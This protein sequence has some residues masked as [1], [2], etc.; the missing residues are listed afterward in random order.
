M[1][2]L[3]IHTNISFQSKFCSNSI[4][5]ITSECAKKNKNTNTDL[6][7]IGIKT[8]QTT[9]DSFTKTITETEKTV[10][11]I[12]KNNPKSE[13]ILNIIHASEEECQKA[14]L[15]FLK[16]IKNITLSENE[17]NYLLKLLQ[18][19]FPKEPLIAKVWGLCMQNGLDVYSLL[20]STF[21]IDEKS[22]KNILD[23][24]LI[25]KYKD[26]PEEAL[27]IGR[28][29]S[30]ETM[31]KV[32]KYAATS[33][34]TTRA[35]KISR[36]PAHNDTLTNSVLDLISRF[37]KLVQENNIN[38]TFIG[39]YE[40]EMTSFW[41]GAPFTLEDIVSKNKILDIIEKKTDLSS[42]LYYVTSIL[43]RTEKKTETAIADI[44][45]RDDISIKTA[46]KIILSMNNDKNRDFIKS[47][48]SNKSLQIN[49]ENFWQ[50]IRTFDLL[51]WTHLDSEKLKLADR[52]NLMKELQSVP[53]EMK[54]IFAKYDYDIDYYIKTINKMLGEKVPVVIIPS[55]IQID[56]LSKFL[57]NNN[58]ETEK[59]LKTHDFTKYG[60]KGIPLKYSRREF[61]KNVDNLL[62][63]LTEKE[64]NLI[65]K[66]F[67]LKRGQNYTDGTV[68]YDGILNNRKFGIN[69][70]RY[71]VQDTANRILQEI[72]KFTI[73]NESLFEDV[74]LKKFFDSIIKGLPEFTSVIGKEQH[75]A[76][77]YS[78]D[79][80]TLKVLQSAMN[81]P[82]YATLS[83]KDKTILKMSVL[84]HDIGKSCGIRD[85]GHANTS[86]LYTAGI[87]EKIKFSDDVKDRIINIVKNHHWFEKYNMGFLPIEDVVARCMHPGDFKIYQIIA[88]ADLENVNKFFH[89]GDKS[90][91]AKTQTEFDKYFEE[92]MKPIDEALNQVY[93]RHNPVFYTRFIGNGKLFPVQ[94]VKIDNE[95]VELRVLD[96]N[97]LTNDANLEQYGF[98]P[99]T[100]KENVRFLVHMTG[101][102][103]ANLESVIYLA[104]NR[105]NHNAW[106]T[107]IIKPS[108]N[109]TYNNYDYGFVVCADQANFANAFF[110]NIA[111]GNNKTLES[112][113]DFL[114]GKILYYDFSKLGINL[115][116][117]ERQ[118]LVNIIIEKGYLKNIN[119]DIV[120]GNKI[121]NQKQLFNACGGD[122]WLYL[123]D[124]MQKNLKKEGFNLNENEYADLTAYLMSKKDLTQITKPNLRGEFTG[125]S[126]KIGKHSIP[127]ITLVDCLNRTLDRLF[128]SGHVQN[129]V[130]TLDMI[131]SALLAKVNKLDQCHHDFLVTAKKYKDTIPIII[132]KNSKST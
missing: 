17:L 77:E 47:L 113:R 37:E 41:K 70:T 6:I 81:N 99:G 103:I 89:L 127:A 11:D 126:I 122:S 21:A 66:H 115:T 88:K 23:K 69:N 42:S 49:P 101:P 32:S 102:N 78:V 4:L 64:Q 118:Q 59:I 7:N 76:H 22:A 8:I 129:E 93:A 13:E 86:A 90:G 58:P 56:F 116:Q 73:K 45:Q 36:L 74:K 35:R 14:Q 27:L 94:K 79:I 91:G 18:N 25:E 43:N 19:Q 72:E 121:I 15:E 51:C 128:D 63:D 97:K 100:T 83:D 2:I 54:P 62:S 80:H 114:F 46:N 33:T 31:D 55:Y 92:K 117:A 16:L 5:Q 82:L 109:I 9:Q 40:L 30:E 75:S 50:H 60:K 108:K 48:C 87:F 123:R 67:G 125:Q 12:L 28:F 68:S 131:P 110:E 39:E 29:D 20:K 104:Q 120:L 106:S 3:N 53:K 10:R 95:E 105:L 65:L 119:E 52:I 124:I 130:I 24:N 85:E 71:E 26:T 38:N 61:C 57:A 112:F 98:P 34:K 111:S 84:L 132:Q 107:S 96:L 1:K 44:L